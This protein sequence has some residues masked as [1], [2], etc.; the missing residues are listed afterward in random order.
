MQRKQFIV[1]LENE[2]EG[3]RFIKYL[4]HNGFNNI[5]N[6]S[7]NRLKIK[8]LVIDNSIFFPTNA[9]C[10]AA[11]SSQRIKPI[12]TDEFKAEFEADHN[13]VNEL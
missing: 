6:V 2:K 12:S 5:H 1:K 4:E 11:L 8:V 10:L 7:F 13:V 3:N 9:T